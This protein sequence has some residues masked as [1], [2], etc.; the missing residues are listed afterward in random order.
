[1]AAS[2]LL[3]CALAVCCASCFVTKQEPKIE[4]RI[5]WGNVTDPDGDCPVRIDKSKL[6]ITIPATEHD[7]NPRLKMNAPRILRE[8]DGDFDVQVKVS[9]AFNPGKQPT[10]GGFPFNGAGLLVWQNDSNYLRLERN[11]WW[12][13]TQGKHGCYPPL[14]E[15]FKNGQYM[16]TDPPG[17]LRP[18]FQG[19]ST[20]LRLERRGQV[21]TALYSHDGQQ[22]R[23]VSEIVVAFPDRVSVGMAALNTSDKIFVVEFEEFKL[24]KP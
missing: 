14:F 8:V 2:R 21:I 19:R 18:F 20:Y 23:Q 10:G 1:M 12:D 15:Y 9:G 3:V 24:T 5:D 17:T 6:T 4:P 13:T 22:W 7:L 11:L 16:D